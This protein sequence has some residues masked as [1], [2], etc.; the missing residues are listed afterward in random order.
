MDF[1]I[2]SGLL[3]ELVEDLKIE[4]KN[5]PSLDDNILGSKVKNAIRDVIN[6]RKYKSVGYDDSQILDDLENYYSI[7]KSIALY[8]Y[9]QSGAE[10]QVV[11]DENGISRT[12]ADRKSL[13][14]GV[15]AL[16]KVF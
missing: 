12:W 11:H 1:T 16:V 5:D 4:L 7:I 6:A 10:G 15:V 2:F 8:D 3:N 14:S 13:F 9:N